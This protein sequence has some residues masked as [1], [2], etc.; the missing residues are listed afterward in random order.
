MRKKW[1]LFIVV[2]A[3]MTIGY[4]SNSVT[5]RYNINSKIMMDL[6]DFKFEIESVTLGDRDISDSITDDKLGFSFLSNL[7]TGIS[8]DYQ[9]NNLST[10]YDGEVLLTCTPAH[11]GVRID[12]EEVLVAA[13]TIGENRIS[14]IP[15]NVEE[16]SGSSCDVEV[17]TTWS[18]TYSNASESFEVP[19]KGN[20]KIEYAG[21]AGGSGQKYIV[22]TSN[23]GGGTGS[24]GSAYSTTIDLNTNDIISY[25]IGKKGGNGSS[26]TAGAAGTPGGKK[27]GSGVYTNGTLFAGAGGGGGGYTLVSI[28]G[29]ETLS[30]NGGKGHAGGA[31]PGYTAGAGGAGGSHS[32]NSGDLT[33][34][35]LSSNTGN[36]YVKITLMSVES[37]EQ[38]IQ[39]E[40]SLNIKGIA[41]TEKV[42]TCEYNSGYSWE[43]DYTGNE[44]TFSIPCDGTYKLETWGAEGE[45]ETISYGGYSV[46]LINLVKNNS[47]YINIGEQ[48]DINNASNNEDKA[49][50]VA[51]SSGLLNQ[52]SDNIDNLLI[53][54]GGGSDYIGN[55]RLTNKAM[56]CYNCT[57]SDD[58]T[59]KTISTTCTNQNPVENCSK[60]GNGYVKITKVS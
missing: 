32:V 14:F 33:I 40:C 10:E 31:Y 58:V 49:T 53:V 13:Q 55:T 28:N 19:C 37:Q 4:A 9:V 43:F 46:G 41:R 29:V 36:G 5:F 20:Y 56:Y 52:L 16:S 34:T 25:S 3:L 15:S 45:T 12:Q 27:G 48:E 22:G 50:Y 42:E 24:S 11:Q 38:V 1:T 39:Y 26:S 30:A 7:G 59:T 51:L 2:I 6:E 54:A 60:Q 21:A 44:Q 17:G 35:S 57:E 8:V 23:G 47:L 18:Y